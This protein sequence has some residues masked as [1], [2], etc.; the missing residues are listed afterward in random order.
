MGS[1]YSTSAGGLIGHVTLL[2]FHDADLVSK[3]SGPVAQVSGALSFRTAA[4]EKVCGPNGKA[5]G[6]M[7]DAGCAETIGGWVRP[8]SQRPALRSTLGRLARSARPQAWAP[9]MTR[10]TAHSSH[11]ANHGSVHASKHSL[12]GWPLGAVQPSGTSI[13][14]SPQSQSSVLSSDQTRPSPQR[15][16]RQDLV[17]APSSLL[18][19]PSSHSSSLPG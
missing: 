3:V 8:E 15:A 10:G 13:E 17:Q 18:S 4:D 2:L 19:G 5:C 6:H 16:A 12:S 11:A 1:R 7:D 9:I 14:P